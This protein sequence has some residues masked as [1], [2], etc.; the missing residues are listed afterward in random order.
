MNQLL[1]YIIQLFKIYDQGQVPSYPDPT[2][3]IDLG[4]ALTQD[5]IDFVKKLKK[6]MDERFTA[7]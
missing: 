4:S 2:P 6:E 5:E 3:P 7:L 1:T